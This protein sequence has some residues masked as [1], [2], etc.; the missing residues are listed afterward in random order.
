MQIA[1]D[2][3]YDDRDRICLGVDEREKLLVR[4]LLDRPLGELF[5]VAERLKNISVVIFDQVGH[6]T[7]VSRSGK[8]TLAVGFW[9]QKSA[10]AKAVT[11]GDVKQPFASR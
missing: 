4:H 1:G 5:V 6:R 3:L 8:L 9:P 7:S 11:H 2:V 10:S